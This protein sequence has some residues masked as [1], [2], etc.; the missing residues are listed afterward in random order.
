MSPT[1]ELPAPPSATRR[2]LAA[3]L[4]LAVTVPLS[5]APL[6]GN[7]DVPGFKALLSLY[8]SSL[9]ETA[10]PLATLAMSLV[11][12]SVQFF[13]RD[14]FS[15][16][17]LRRWF[18]ALVCSLFALLLLLAYVHSQSVVRVYFRGGTMSESYI[19]SSTRGPA[20]PC[21][22]GDSDAVCITHLGL[23][24][25][26][27]SRCWSERD[28]RR[29]SFFLTLL[30]VLLMSGVGALVGLLVMVRTQRKKKPAAK[31]R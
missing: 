14:S 26:Y 20:C 8:P 11:A 25:G 10:L 30:Y 2:W 15:G 28:V 24:P 18:I 31:A 3:L 17:R 29:T 22:P 1:P 9:R 27:H 7:W 19:V 13:S 21:D 23:D 12:I 5:L 16:R 6:L 4:A